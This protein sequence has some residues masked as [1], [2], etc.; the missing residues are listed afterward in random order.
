[1]QRLSLSQH[2]SLVIQ[3][4]TPNTTHHHHTPPFFIPLS[5][6]AT[7]KVC[8]GYPPNGPNKVV[9]LM[10]QPPPCL[11]GKVLRDKKTFLWPSRKEF[12]K[13]YSNFLVKRE[14]LKNSFPH[15][16][17]GHTHMY[18][19]IWAYMYCYRYISK[20]SHTSLRLPLQ[21]L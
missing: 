18:A 6:A 9:S 13:E 4:C 7:S 10:P 12:F 19:W 5:Q 16:S 15:P 21:W 14:K 8:K 1:M 3:L 20:V 2:A 11:C 17:I